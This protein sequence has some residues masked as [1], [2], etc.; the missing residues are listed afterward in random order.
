MDL[1]AGED[2]PVGADELGAGSSSTTESTTST[3]SAGSSEVVVDSVVVELTEDS[4]T[5]AVDPGPVSPY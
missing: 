2:V 5:A 3:I 1:T 4:V